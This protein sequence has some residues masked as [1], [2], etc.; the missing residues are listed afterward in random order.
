VAHAYFSPT[1]LHL[2]HAGLYAVGGLAG[3]C[4]QV[5]DRQGQQLHLDTHSAGPFRAVCKKYS[6]S[7]RSLNELSNAQSKRHL[8]P[9]LYSANPD[10]QLDCALRHPNEQYDVHQQLKLAEPLLYGFQDFLFYFYRRKL[11][12]A[13]AS[14]VHDPLRALY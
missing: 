5:L 3:V 7:W 4:C 2:P 9:N 6:H 1:R 8:T 13:A 11:W 12:R 14:A 10:V